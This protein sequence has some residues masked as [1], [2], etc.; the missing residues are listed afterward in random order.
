MLDSRQSPSLPPGPIAVNASILVGWRVAGPLGVCGGH[1]G[2]RPAAADHSSRSSP[3]RRLRPTGGG[4]LLKGCRGGGRHR[5]RGLRHGGEYLKEKKLLPD[6][7]MAAASS[8]HG[9][10]K[11]AWYSGPP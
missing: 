7:I 6:L 1:S 11:L 8:P 2:H 10:L 3:L 9:S 5:Q 4:C